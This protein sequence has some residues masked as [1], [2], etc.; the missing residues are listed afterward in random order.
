MAL[1]RVPRVIGLFLV[2][3]LAIGLAACQGGGASPGATASAGSS[4]AATSSVAAALSSFGPAQ[5][6]ATA[7]AT[8]VP[9]DTPDPSGVALDLA[10]AASAV[11]DLSSY[12]MDVTVTTGGAVQKLT[13]VSTS[14]PTASAEYTLSGD[15]MKETTFVTIAG[16]G[17]WVRQGGVW[18]AIPS[19][20]Q[21]YISAF[22]ALAPDKI[23]STYALTSFA[24]ALA[25]VGTVTKNGVQA[26]HYHLDAN[27][28]GA[29]T[30][31]EFPSDGT[32]DAWVAT[33]G[34]YLVGMAYG[35][36][37]P[38]TGTKVMVAVDVTR[39]NDPTIAITAPSS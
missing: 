21:T 16:S 5:T 23:I 22:D 20:G 2:L 14:T 15:N 32:F 37:N 30:A 17:A 28:A 6:S 1:S 26:V 27:S 36:T 31:S 4:S 29:A 18:T 25:D 33:D 19:G 13:V 12:Q 38:T 7:A 10:M 39:V 34:G 9:L 8:M 3:L 24:N 35:G 11:A